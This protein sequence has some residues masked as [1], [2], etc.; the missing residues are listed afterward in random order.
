MKPKMLHLYKFSLVAS[1][2]AIILV[3]SACSATP[4]TVPVPQVTTAPQ[5]VQTTSQPAPSTTAVRPATPN[6]AAKAVR[7]NIATT[8]LPDGRIGKNYSQAIVV[9]EGMPP[10]T[11]SITDG[12]L[13]TGLYL[14]TGV[15][16]GIPTAA[17]TFTFT[18]QAADSNGSLT[19]ANL[20]IVIPIAPSISTAAATPGQVGKNYL[21]NITLSGGVAPFYWT[22]F[23]GSL[24][25][26]LTLNS[27][28]ISGIPT[29]T[30]TFNFG[31]QVTD[32]NGSAAT[33]NLSI[34][35]S[36]AIIIR[37]TTLPAGEISTAYQQSLSAAEGVSPYEWTITDGS[38]PAGLVLKS[39]IISGT[40]R[41]DGTF[42]FTVQVADSA[43]ATAKTSLTIN[44][45]PTPT[46]TT[47]SLP[48]GKVGTPYSQ[49][50]AVA[51]GTAPY[52]WTVY[53]GSLP[54]GLNLIVNTG[55]ISGT[56]TSA[57]KA[58]FTVQVA[59]SN[60]LTANAD[61]FITIE[62]ASN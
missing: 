8:A 37:N 14:N 35:I 54:R 52:Q 27:G 23:A 28:V 10:Y 56:P 47:A 31:V 32:S 45:V 57:G 39:G 20:S 61:L 48:G 58:S 43:G 5:P 2:A 9:N 62:A 19:S 50:L 15:I 36:R 55:V 16:S 60:G 6:P 3:L 17:G 44:I 59:D 11:W 4:S 29:T 34:S 26:G 12:A 22:I 7:P 40:P 46:L 1:L 30:G 42:N 25:D 24:P 41:A 38:L 49:N 21:Q 13:P 53:V 33:A 51:G 18:I